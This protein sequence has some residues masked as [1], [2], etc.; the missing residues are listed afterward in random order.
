M[1]GNGPPPKRDSQRRRRNAPTKGFAEKV[2]A[3]DAVRGPDL[4]GR[5][6]AVGRRFY[7]ALR[8]SGQAQFFEPSDWSAA[9][10]VVL[11]IDT[12]V[13]KPSAT[14]LDAI[15]HGMSA[16]LVTE[17]DRRRVRLE[18]ERP[19]AEVERAGSLSWIDQYRGP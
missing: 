17:G 9:E 3:P 10:L 16:L 8:R 14:M 7:E 18:L 1:A 15:R 6:S 13:A 5:H 11:A 19:A 4:V 12:F 2:T